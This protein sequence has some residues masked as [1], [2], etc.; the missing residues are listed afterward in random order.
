MLRPSVH[1]FMGTSCEKPLDVVL[2]KL[3]KRVKK[4]AENDVGEIPRYGNHTH[5]GFKNQR[6]QNTA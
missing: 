2:S 6:F 5:I 1:I 4:N 3:E